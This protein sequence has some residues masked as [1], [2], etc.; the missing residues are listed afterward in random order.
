MVETVSE[1]LRARLAVYRVKYSEIA[2]ELGVSNSYISSALAGRCTLSWEMFC[3]ICSKIGEDPQALRKRFILDFDQ[4]P[5][6]YPS[7]SAKGW[8]PRDIQ[9]LQE[10]ERKQRQETERG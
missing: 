5:H 9:A 3:E 6:M 8:R 10:F 1:Y 4:S 2:R 7:I